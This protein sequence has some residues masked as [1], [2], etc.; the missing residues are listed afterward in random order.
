MPDNVVAENGY[1]LLVVYMIGAS[2]NVISSIF[3]FPRVNY[4]DR[5]IRVDPAGSVM[6]QGS[7]R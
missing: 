3:I 6:Q 5:F 4:R 1:W 7:D 2:G